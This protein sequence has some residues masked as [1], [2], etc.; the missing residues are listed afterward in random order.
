M[1]PGKAIEVGGWSVDNGG[2]IITWDYLAGAN[3]QWYAIDAG[4]GYYSIINRHSGLAIDV[5]SFSLDNGG[6]IQQWE[7]LGGENQK[8]KAISI[9]GNGVDPFLPYLHNDDNNADGNWY[10]INIKH[11]QKAFDIGG[12]ATANNSP[13]IQ[14]DYLE[15]DNQ[16]WKFNDA[17]NGYFTIESK[18]ATGKFLQISYASAENGVQLVISDHTGADIQLWRVEAA[19]DGYYRLIN[20]YSNKSLDIEGYFYDSGARIWQWDYFVGDNQKF[21]PVLVSG[22]ETDPWQQYLP[23]DDQFFRIEIRHSGKFIET[24]NASSDN[25]ANAQQS[26]YSDGEY[27]FWSLTD[28]G[29]G[30]FRI[31]PKI[32]QSRCLEIGGWSVDNG[33]NAM[34]WDYFGNDNQLWAAEAVDGGYYRLINKNSGKSLD[35]EGAF[36][37]DGANIWQW[38]YTNGY[39][40][41]FRAYT[42][43]KSNQ[44]PFLAFSLYGEQSGQDDV[45]NSLGLKINELDIYPNP[46]S[47]SFRVNNN[48]GG[49]INLFTMSG[50]LVISQ[51]VDT[52]EKIDVNILSN[53]IYIIEFQTKD[54]VYK[55]KLSVVHQ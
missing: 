46:A 1:T 36:S 29:E 41:H 22:T 53:G 13:V 38:D 25:G 28:A 48:E 19:D 47:N 34:L 9:V 3:Q 10:W 37:F 7:Y 21:K 31:T 51:E 26:S 44:D 20:K 52:F 33:G 40:Q 11:T 54:K 23:Q 24:A 2:N 35:V 8:I 4:E 5:A 55:S 12:W 45:T 30:Y 32:A 39:Q 14:W 43:A 17:G 50:K 27:Q 15:N 42:Q 49:K 18:Y 6:N 16:I